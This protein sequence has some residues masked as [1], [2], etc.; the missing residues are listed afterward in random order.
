[1]DLHWKKLSKL[2]YAQP[3]TDLPRRSWTKFSNW[4]PELLLAGDDT[5]IVKSHTEKRQRNER[6]NEPK[7]KTRL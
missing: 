6:A 2:Y 3:S 1:M 5:C 7:R 4:K